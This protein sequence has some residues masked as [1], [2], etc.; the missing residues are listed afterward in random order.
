MMSFPFLDCMSLPPHGLLPVLLLPRLPTV[1]MKFPFGVSH[2][3]LLWFR[4]M[5]MLRFSSS[6]PAFLAFLPPPPLQLFALNLPCS[7]AAVADALPLPVNIHLL[8]LLLQK[9]K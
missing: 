5:V 6:A 7:L 8:L 3:V 2:T 4:A 1:M 9:F